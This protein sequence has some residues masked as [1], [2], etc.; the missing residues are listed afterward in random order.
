MRQRAGCQQ[1]FVLRTTGATLPFT[2]L[3]P[4]LT[5]S[6]HETTPPSPHAL[7]NLQNHHLYRFV[8]SSEIVDKTI[9]KPQSKP[10][11]TRPLAEMCIGAT[12]H[13]A[14]LYTRG[15]WYLKS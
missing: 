1:P 2:L 9:P 10:R 12:E 7:R 14:T 11:Y 3:I 5:A 8:P 4:H 6:Q 15:G 13:R